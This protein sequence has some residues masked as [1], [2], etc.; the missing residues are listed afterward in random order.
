MFEQI[1]K[2]IF[3]R[4]TVHT[5]IRATVYNTYVARKHIVQPAVNK[6]NKRFTL[7]TQEYHV[8]GPLT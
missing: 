4:T 6:T 8:E 1:L 2:S 3:F 5:P 7:N